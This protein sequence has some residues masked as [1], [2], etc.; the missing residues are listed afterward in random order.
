M[1]NDNKKSP[2]NGEGVAEFDEFCDKF[3]VEADKRGC[4]QHFK[5]EAKEVSGVDNTVP[6]EVFPYI[7]PCAAGREEEFA[8]E[9]KEAKLTALEVKFLRQVKRTKKLFKGKDLGKEKRKAVAALL[10]KL[11]DD[12]AAIENGFDKT[13]HDLKSACDLHDRKE[14]LFMD[15]RA[16]AI[17]LLHQM[18]GDHPM[19]MIYLILKHVGPKNAW[20]RLVDIFDLES[21]TD[22]YLSSV[23]TKMGALVFSRKLGKV[24]DHIAFLDKLNSALVRRGRPISDGQLMNYLIEAIRR[25]KDALALYGEGIRSIFM[26]NKPRHVAIALLTRIEHADEVNAEVMGKKIN[27]AGAQFACVQGAFA[28]TASTSKGKSNGKRKSRVVEGKESGGADRECSRCG[29]KDHLRRNC[30]EEVYCKPCNV[31][32]HSEKCCWKLHPEKI[33]PNF[34]RFKVGASE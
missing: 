8:L 34:K 28:G 33:P 2:F 29:S 23:T 11:E 12:K 5:W 6:E 22:L 26:E 4:D 15:A 16:Q 13:V 20:K 24:S 17:A 14:K 21:Q 18:L 31:H 19:S 1:N 30:E 27:S 7:R 10:T 32:T 25:D 9:K 3:H